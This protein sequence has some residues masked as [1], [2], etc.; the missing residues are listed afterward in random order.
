MAPAKPRSNVSFCQ[1]VSKGVEGRRSCLSWIDLTEEGLILRDQVGTLE[2]HVPFLVG[3]Y[4]K[5]I[6]S[7]S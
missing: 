3:Q 5:L 1:N 2:V 6:F 4:R 7:S